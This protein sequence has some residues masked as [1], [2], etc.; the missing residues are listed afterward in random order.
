MIN[1]LIWKL[2]LFNGRI[3][4]LIL[5]KPFAEILP[6]SLK[7]K[8]GL[9]TIKRMLVLRYKKSWAAKINCSKNAVWFLFYG[10]GS[11]VSKVQSHYN[12]TVSFLPFSS[13]VSR[14]SRYSIDRPRK[15]E[16]LSSPWSRPVVSNLG[17]LD[18]QSTALSTRLL[19][20]LTSHQ[21][22]WNYFYIFLSLAVK[23]ENKHLKVYCIQRL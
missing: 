16:R 3:L 11:T 5:L 12:E 18:F 17:T 6:F 21:E 22:T 7:W 19:H 14:N 8:L 13:H 2:K 23:F 1:C 4:R 20:V 10:W 9:F 15:E